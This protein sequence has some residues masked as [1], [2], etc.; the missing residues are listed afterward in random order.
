MEP[1]GST[2][3]L[4]GRTSGCSVLGDPLQLVEGNQKRA[5]AKAHHGDVQRPQTDEFARFLGGHEISRPE[6]GHR[7]SRFQIRQRASELD[8]IADDWVHDPWAM[9]ASYSRM[10]TS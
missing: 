3:P 10:V 7:I 5:A 2:E 4:R 6:H 9:D 8:A 1:K